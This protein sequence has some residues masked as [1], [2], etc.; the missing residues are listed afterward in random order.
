MAKCIQ[1]TSLPFKGLKS[2]CVTADTVRCRYNRGL[3]GTSHH[4]GQTEGATKSV[5]TSCFESHRFIVGEYRATRRLN[6]AATQELDKKEPAK[7]GRIENR[8]RKTARCGALMATGINE[9][10]MRPAP[11]HTGPR[12]SA[13]GTV[14]CRGGRGTDVRRTD[15][16]RRDCELEH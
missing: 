13:S 1:L 16:R 6:A 2:R 8:A 5:S 15:E 11:C 3:L 10:T 7:S 4:R 14:V 12:S 9:C